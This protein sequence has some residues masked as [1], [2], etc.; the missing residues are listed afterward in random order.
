M[1]K[2]DIINWLDGNQKIVTDTAYQIWEKAE[3]SFEEFFA[4]K[5]QAEVL[6]KAGFKV[7]LGLQDMPTAIV[8][9]Y[10]S[11]KPIIGILGEYDAL[12]DLSQKATSKREAIKEGDPG[13][14]CGHAL[15]GAAG[16]GAAA[17]LK[18]AIDAGA[19]KGTVR[20]YGCPAEEV[21]AGKPFMAK[22]GVFDDLDAC[23]TW[24]A[25]HSNLIW[26]CD[27]LAMNAA[28]FHFTGVSA[29]GT[30][31]PHQGRS[32]LDAIELMNVS[33][34]Y[35]REHVDSR[36]RL[37]YSMTSG[38]GF[39]TVVP[40]KATSWY[41]IFA[42]TRAY[43]EEVYERIINCAKGAALM[44]GT[45][46]EV[47]FL[48]GCYDVLPNKVISDAMRENMKAIGDIQYDKEDW[49]LAEEITA[50]LT[51]EDREAVMQTYFQGPESLDKVLRP[52]F[53]QNDDTMNMM[54]G[55]TDV[56][57]V[58]Y[59]TPLAQFTA[60]AYA[61]GVPPH[62]W[63]STACTGSGI[64]LKAALYAS[65]VLAATVFDLMTD[66]AML[67]SAKAEFKTTMKGNKYKCPIPDGV[68]PKKK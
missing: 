21:Y 27:F 29:H 12:D 61:T 17:A 48:A 53:V 24:H 66:A 38:T 39:P 36:C 56:G 59:I 31:S 67:E 26:D 47:E 50:T 13:H 28:L 3:V 18:Q 14:G 8:A 55:S 62:S 22:L 40:E 23:V 43:L 20:Y 35:L 1:N 57:D 46:V 44:T 6:E 49:K 54:M 2:K 5:L 15:L 42:P 10:G 25:A 51:R 60:A 41:H 32:A 58:S 30:A 33:V 45:T 63:Q 16:V 7:T 9:E 34:N 11:G 4:S 65:K 68:L 19:L 52:G 37:N 64:G